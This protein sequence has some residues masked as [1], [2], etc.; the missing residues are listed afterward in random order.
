MHLL[1]P[2]LQTPL[3]YLSR[4]EQRVYIDPDHR[5]TVQR[6]LAAYISVSTDLWR[7]PMPGDD[8]RVP[9]PPDNEDREFEAWDLW[10]WDPRAAPALGDVRILAAAPTHSSLQMT[11]VPVLNDGGGW[12]SATP[13]ALTRLVGGPHVPAVETFGEVTTG[14]RY[15]DR[16]CNGEGIPVRI[17]SW[18]GERP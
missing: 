10:H 12:I 3:G 2:P 8:P 4:G 7:I 14:V 18:A 16:E 6:L 5:D 11:C 13:F 15:P 1:A 9:I 17:L